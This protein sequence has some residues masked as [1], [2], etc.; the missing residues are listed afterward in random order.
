M[1]KRKTNPCVSTT[2]TP[3]SL[4]SLDAALDLLACD[5]FT[6][7]DSLTAKFEQ[8]A[9][10]TLDE[11]AVRSRWDEAVKRYWVI[12]SIDDLCCFGSSNQGQGPGS[13]SG[14][15][16]GRGNGQRV[17][18]GGSNSAS[19]GGS[20]RGSGSRDGVASGTAGQSHA[21]GHGGS[22]DG[23]MDQDE[24]AHD[25]THT[26]RDDHGR[27]VA[28]PH[29]GAV[30]CHQLNGEEEHEWR[31]WQPRVGDVV[32]VHTRNDGWYPGKVCR[33]VNLRSV[34]YAD[35]RSDC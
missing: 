20:R 17:E 29:P 22:H 8:A 1:P 25:Q 31:R 19:A 18:E 21:N 5:T 6:R 11:N 2:S 14:S 12:K 7:L 4:S 16:K 23:D 34:L 32:L 24:P 26:E 35:S 15:R 28:K 13:G 27:K 30:A 10:L 9:G 3:V 33:T